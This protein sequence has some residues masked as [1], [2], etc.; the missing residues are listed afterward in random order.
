MFRN[1]WLHHLRMM[2][3]EVLTEK[4]KGTVLGHKNTSSSGLPEEKVSAKHGVEQATSTDAIVRPDL[5]HEGLPCLSEDT[6][7]EPASTLAGAFTLVFKA[8]P[9]TS[10]L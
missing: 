1:E 6:Q 10:D 5:I 2:G 4:K 8:K 3:L 7:G 9:R